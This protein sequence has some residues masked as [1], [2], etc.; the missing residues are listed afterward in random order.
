[1][2]KLPYQQKVEKVYTSFSVQIGVAA[3]IFGNFLV[4]ALEKQL[5][6]TPDSTAQTV[7][8]IFEWIF[9]VLFLIEL[10]VN[11]YGSWLLAF[12]KSGMLVKF[13]RTL[14]QF[15][16][17]ACESAWRASYSD[18]PCKSACREASPSTKAN[19]TPTCNTCS[20]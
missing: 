3:L 9:C 15:M 19:S 1:M 10:I 5:L 14:D 20:F 13:G 6:P 7:F 12:W 8:T 16:L 11:M 17:V 18:V 4:S 2:W